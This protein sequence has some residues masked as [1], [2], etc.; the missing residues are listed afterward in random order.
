M[1]AR[2]R[3]VLDPVSAQ[4]VDCLI[5][6]GA[7][8]QASLAQLFDLLSRAAGHEMARRH[9]WSWTSSAELDDLARQAAADAMLAI[10]S[11]LDSFRGESRFTTWAYR[12]VALEV[13]NKLRWC[14]WRRNPELSL[15]AV[16]LDCLP[17]Q[18]GSD[19]AAQ[20]EAAELVSAVRQAVEQT[21]TAYQRQVFVAVVLRGTPLDAVAADFGV[22]RNAIY[23]A[24]FDARRKIRAF[25]V[26]GGYVND[27]A[28]A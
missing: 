23:K 7:E 14:Y 22:N 6:E 20:A 13:A 11:K 28:A 1:P 10:L 27:N 3:P 26:A 19:P 21:L 2:A 16:D 4:W 17:A 8:R 12:F 5:G 18:V 15:E 24:I 25:L 9:V